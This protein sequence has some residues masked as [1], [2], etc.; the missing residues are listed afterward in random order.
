MIIS[1]QIQGSKILTQPGIEPQ[2]PN[3]QPVIKAMSHNDPFEQIYPQ[4]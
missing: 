4:K 1:R 2:S 3:S